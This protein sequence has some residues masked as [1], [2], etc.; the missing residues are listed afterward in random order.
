MLVAMVQPHAISPVAPDGG[1]DLRPAD[2]QQTAAIA[3]ATMNARS[4]TI[5]RVCKL[6][7]LVASQPPN[8]TTA[9]RI[10]ASMLNERRG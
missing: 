5:S 6:A 10:P 8:T 9:R 4:L 2:Q 7:W 1:L 3:G